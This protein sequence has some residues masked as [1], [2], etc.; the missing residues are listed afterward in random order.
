MVILTT[1]TIL[2][3]NGY[4]VIIDMNATW[5]PPCWSYHQSGEL[6]DL[7]VNHGPAGQPGVSATTTDDVYVF[8]V[9]SD[10]Q[11]T[12]ADLAGTTQVLKE[13][14]LQEHSFQLSMMAH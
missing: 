11:L 10:D 12:A 5:C 8:M 3:D 14:G 7:W 6:E 9:E 4:T 2:L 13:I 1:F